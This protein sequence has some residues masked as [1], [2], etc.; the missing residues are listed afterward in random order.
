MQVELPS[1]LWAKYNAPGHACWTICQHSCGLWCSPPCRAMPKH[2]LPRA[3]HDTEIKW[4]CMQINYIYK[5]AIVIQHILQF[6]KRVSIHQSIKL[7]FRH[8]HVSGRDYNNI[9]MQSPS[10]GVLLKDLMQQLLRLIVMS[11]IIPISKSSW[12]GMMDSVGRHGM[13]WTRRRMTNRSA[14]LFLRCIFHVL[15]PLS[16]M[17]DHMLFQTHDS[18]FCYTLSA[19]SRDCR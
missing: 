16:C 4:P 10:G 15:L 11:L 6:R 18:G 8:G 1:V 19:W 2:C 13:W 5:P 3:F 9:C 14:V 12:E 7:A 17:V